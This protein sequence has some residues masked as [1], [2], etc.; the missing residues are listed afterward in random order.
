MDNE[1][2]EK[3]FLSNPQVIENYGLLRNIGVFRYI[4]LLNKEIRDYKNLLAGAAD[5]FIRTSID[6]IMDAAVWQISD[7]FL[8]SFIV[9]LWKP[10]QNKDEVTI[11]GYQN[12]KTI[13]IPINLDNIGAFE[14]FFQNHR[15]PADFAELM[16]KMTNPA[17]VT[18]LSALQPELVVPILG[19]S[20]LYGL[21]M[22]G[23]KML[24]DA[25]TAQELNFLQQLMSFVS[26]GIQNHLHYEHSV[27]DVKTGL[28]NHGFFITRLT[29]EISRAKRTGCSSSLI[30]IDVDNFKLFNDHY[31]HMAGDR[32][33]EHIALRIKQNVRTEDIPSRFGGEEFTILLPN[34]D[35]DTALFVAERLRRAIAD[36]QVPWNIPLPQVTISLGIVTFNKD[37]DIPADDMLRRADAA[38]YR[39]KEEGRNRTSIWRPGL[40]F[41][42]ENPHKE[43]SMVE[44]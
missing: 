20:G 23:H 24:G 1:Q 36:M 37:V 19:P 31:G 34:S 38:L 44:P 29:E 35:Q 12:Y 41:K 15:R 10:L 26:Q 32:V 39:S 7:H 21:I 42:M 9:F 5:I 30:A 27:R 33:L 16:E 22:V 14:S 17:A 4:E 2:T 6:E 8:P 25:Y 11:K 28:Y 3:D 18:A 43:S 13:D 40:L